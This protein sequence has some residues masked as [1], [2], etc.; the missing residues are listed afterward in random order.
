M[1]HL[2]SGSINTADKESSYYISHKTDKMT[3][4]FFINTVL[5]VE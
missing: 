3:I 1:K 2:C 5:P 4:V